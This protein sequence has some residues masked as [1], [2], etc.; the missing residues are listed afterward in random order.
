[1][2]K[3]E[4]REITNDELILRL[5]KMTVSTTVTKGN[6]KTAKIICNELSNRGIIDGPLYDEW[7]DFYQT[8]L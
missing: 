2:T 5:C 7:L 3:K 8:Y 6:I 1:M 4:A